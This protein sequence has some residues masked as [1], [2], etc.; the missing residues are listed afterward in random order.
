MEILLQIRRD[1]KT[2]SMSENMWPR[3]TWRKRI[4]VKRT[5]RLY[6]HEVTIH[7]ERKKKMQF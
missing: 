6:S 7:T 5:L 3:V 2:M 4:T 1:G